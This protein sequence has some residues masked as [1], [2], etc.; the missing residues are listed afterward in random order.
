M[1]V[2]RINRGLPSLWLAMNAI[3]IVVFLALASRAWIEPEL[4]DVP[5]AS[6]G[7]AFVWAGL[8]FPV[9]GFVALA[10]IVFAAVALR[11]FIKAKQWGGA[12]VL[13]L[14]SIAWFVALL[15][16]NMHHGM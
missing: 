6:G 10:H 7:D 1:G 12:A 11:C 13:L 5:G 4:A 9:L 2:R 3:G 14:S 16:D 15:F 8:V